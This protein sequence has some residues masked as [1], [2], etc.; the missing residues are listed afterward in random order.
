MLPSTMQTPMPGIIHALSEISLG[1]KAIPRFLRSTRAPSGSRD[2]TF[3]W[4]CADVSR[5]TIA[6]VGAGTYGLS[7]ATHLASRRVERRIFGRADVVL[8]P[9]YGGQGQASF[10]ILP[11][12]NKYLYPDACERIGAGRYE[13][14]AFRNAHDLLW[15]GS[16]NIRE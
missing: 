16:Y 10:E 14:T 7:L 9:D 11:L 1:I 15:T 2:L 3:S 4:R 6:I 12:R 13:H 8:L 5:G